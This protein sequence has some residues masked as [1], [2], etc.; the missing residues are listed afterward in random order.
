MSHPEYTVA[1]LR[2]LAGFASDDETRQHLCQVYFG[3]DF[4]A[5]TNGHRLVRIS[6]PED[7]KRDFGLGAVDIAR[8]LVGF[9]PSTAVRVVSA[10]D[11][12]SK[13]S[14]ELSVLDDVTDITGRAARR[15]VGRVM[16]RG[17]WGSFPP[18][19]GVIPACVRDGKW[20]L[21]GDRKLSAHAI[22]VKYLEGLG[23][24]TDAFDMP[25]GIELLDAPGALDPIVY[26]Q[27]TDDRTLLVVVMPWRASWCDG[28]YMKKR[29]T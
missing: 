16:I 5:A 1:Q 2:A 24:I 26:G 15:V 25:E 6:I 18:I 8:W 23:A 7:K 14:V 28:N 27:K 9:P 12:A 20:P 4:V 17:D 22:A 11:V 10:A 19:E 3:P 29:N 21:P 13:T